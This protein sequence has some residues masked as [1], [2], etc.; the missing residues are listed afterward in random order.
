M[1]AKDRPRESTAAPEATA[2]SRYS[3]DTDSPDAVPYFNWDV[4][5]TNAQVRST[6]RTGS[7]PERLQWMSRTMR[8]E[9]RIMRE[10]RYADVWKYLSLRRD[11]LPRW[12]RL[13]AMLGRRRRFWS[14][15]I[16]EWRRA[17]LIE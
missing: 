8:V 9:A 13:E 14:F 10:A 1:A 7:E 3:M 6:L 15:L 16:G 17:G 4:A 5:I 11:V 12:T 2:T